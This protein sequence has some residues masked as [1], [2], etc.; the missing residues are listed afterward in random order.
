M[1]ITPKPA[2]T[3]VRLADAATKEDRAV[4]DLLLPP[5]ALDQLAEWRAKVTARFSQPPKTTRKPQTPA[6]KKKR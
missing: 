3:P 4:A 6:P 1:K 5:S 2:A